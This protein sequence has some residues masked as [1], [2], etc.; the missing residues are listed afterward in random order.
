MLA[1]DKLSGVVLGADGGSRVSIEMLPEL[2]RRRS[3][4]Y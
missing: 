2:R 1:M 4:G 3:E